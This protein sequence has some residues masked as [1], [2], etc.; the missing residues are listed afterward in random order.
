MKKKDDKTIQPGD[1]VRFESD[2]GPI[3]G[4]VTQ[5]KRD[6]SN[7]QEHAVIDVHGFAAGSPWNMPLDRL[8]RTRRAA[9]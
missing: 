4:T 8:E 9:A 3:T 2:I 6:V 5:V 7:A 1:T